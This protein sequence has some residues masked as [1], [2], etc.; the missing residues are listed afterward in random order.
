MNV[1]RNIYEPIHQQLMAEIPALIN[2]QVEDLSLILG[3]LFEP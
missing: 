1:A 2:M 3:S